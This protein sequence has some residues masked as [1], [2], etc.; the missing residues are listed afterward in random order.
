MIPRRWL[1]AR[2]AITAQA[3]L[4]PGVPTHAIADPML[5]TWPPADPRGS[6]VIGYELQTTD[7]WLSSSAWN[8]SVYHGAA[9]QHEL[10]GRM[11]PDSDY[12]LRVRAHNGVGYS[13]WSKNYTLRTE[14]SGACG[15][16]A[17]VQIFHDKAATLSGTVGDAIMGCITDPDP[18]TCISGKVHVSLGLST[19][20][21]LC[22]GH[23]AICMQDSCFKDCVLG[24]AHG[25]ACVACSKLHCT[26][27][28]LACAG[29][30]DWA[31][32]A[33]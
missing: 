17:D 19:P 26:P 33:A 7:W 11:L 4:A 5:I 1:T 9:R 6:E 15:N 25:A 2:T 16:R 8:A 32:P 24:S 12:E 31:F 10:T 21:G 3:P 14:P 27:A 22:W 30:P 28:M 20:C 18:P 13:S 23:D 29:L